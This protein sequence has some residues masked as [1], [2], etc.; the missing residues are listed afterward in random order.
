MFSDLW[1]L[2]LALVILVGLI[3]GQGIIIS[4]GVMSLLVGS[5]SWTWNRL[6]LERVIYNRSVSN[7]RVFR[8]EEVELTV[9]I[10][11]KKP[12][13]LAWLQAE[14][15][16]PENVELRGGELHATSRHGILSLRHSTSMGWYERVR[17]SYRLVS[18][19]RGY[20][21]I[22]PATL[23]SG[24][25]FG[26]FNSER[27]E[28]PQEYLLVYPRVAPIPQLELPAARPLGDTRGGL[29]IFEDPSRHAGLRDYQPGDPFNIVDWKAT[30]RHMS[31]QSRIF[32]PTV[33][34][35]LVVV[36]NVDTSEHIW[37]GYL[38]LYLE[39]AVTAA[40]SIAS[41]AF[42]HRYQVGLFSNG[43]PLLADRPLN[44]PPTRNPQQLP[45]ILEALAAVGP[46]NVGSVSKMLTQEAHKFPMGA[47]LI[48]V[49][50]L[51]PEALVE[52]I[53][54]LKKRG[55]RLFVSYVADDK[56]SAVS[57]GVPMYEMG[58][59]LA[60]LESPYAPPSR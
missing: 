25:L 18:L 60:S 17:W 7:K 27:Q 4:L 47:T 56:P 57:Q 14:D 20:Y 16:F 52:T 12:I 32:E 28:S 11:N 29:R 33:T 44:I 9:T 26:F 58:S 3:S 48:L 34:H 22:G 43:T 45:I 55:Y 31:M 50:A 53:D 54:Y 8:G 51:L 38:P 42:E 19:N 30:A 23:K 41:W 10:T 40:A 6:S 13:P 59:Y 5:L 36:L 39:R 1:V 37:E 24:D 46:F 2:F 21:R 49:T 15:D 35:N